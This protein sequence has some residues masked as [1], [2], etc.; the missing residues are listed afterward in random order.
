MNQVQNQYYDKRNE[1]KEHEASYVVFVSEPTDRQSMSR[2]MREVNDVMPAVPRHMHWSDQTITWSIEDHPKIMPTPG[3]YALVL[4][5]VLVGPQMPIKFSR[6]LIDNDSSI[7]IMYHDTM[8]KLGVTKN[9]LQ[10]S[11]T[12]FHGIVPGISCSPMGSIWLD[13]QFGDKWN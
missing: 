5:P 3:A 12:T 10:P 7:N 13:V 2:R 4:D 11:K 1:Y 8:V 6:V 9:M